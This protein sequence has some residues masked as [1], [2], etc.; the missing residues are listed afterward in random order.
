[1]VASRP[2]EN[3]EAYDLYLRG[4]AASRN[5]RNVQTLESA[6]SYYE[7]A[8]KKDSSFG[9]AFCGLSDAYLDMYAL[10][11]DP[12][13]PTK[14]LGAAL[15]AEQL[16]GNRPEVHFSLGSVYRATGKTA[17]AVVEFKRALELAPNSDEGYRRLG[18]AFLAAGKKQ[19]AVESYERATEINPYYSLNYLQLGAAYLEF[20]DNAHA[21]AAFE[22]STELNPASSVG[23]SNIGIAYYRQGKWDQCIPAF[24]KALEIQPSSEAYSNLGTAYFFLKRYDESIKM[25]EKAVELSPGSEVYVGNL[26]D[27]YRA[28]GELQKASLSYEKAIQL[29]F[30]EY[31][32]NPRNAETISSIALYYA[33]EGNS[34]NAVEFIRRARAIKPDDVSLID[35]EA[36]IFALVGRKQDSI[37]SIREAL[38]RGYPAEEIKNDPELNSLHPLPEFQKLLG[39][40][41]LKKN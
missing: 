22:R 5:Q 10:A 35:N 40:Y 19:E 34:S 3:I 13:W 25:Y 9:L 17:E 20:G 31:R 7:Q 14:A 29:A 11:K 38:K 2:T 28:S 12:A 16:A 30:K 41:N 4:R 24:Q 6:I 32:V 36:E 39:E 18:S 8:L 27:A 21:L 33:K 15:E 23:Y 1:M 37:K 26:A